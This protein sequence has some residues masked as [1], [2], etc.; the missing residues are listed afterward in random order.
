M[1]KIISPTI[2]LGLLL[3]ITSVG[4][5]SCSEE[6]AETV[7]QEYLDSEEYSSFKENADKEINER[8]QESKTL[9]EDLQKIST[10]SS[11][12]TLSLPLTADGN[13]L[14]EQ[15]ENISDECRLENEIRT[16]TLLGNHSMPEVN[17]QLVL[18]ERQT[19]YRDDELIAVTVDGEELRSFQ[20]VGIYQ[21]NPTREITTELTL[22]QNG[23]GIRINT[24]TSRNI[25]Y[26]IDQENSIETVYEVDAKG[27][28]REL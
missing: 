18:L 15:L 3:L 14:A 25:Q 20:T 5:I 13:S 26:P 8:S 7:D 24:V 1:Q 17:L 16:I 4:M 9:S 23:S 21:K 22:Q 12:E 28:I 19:V 10:C 27:G 2:L 11:V 6:E